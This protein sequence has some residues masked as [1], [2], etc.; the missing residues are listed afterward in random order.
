M[1]DRVIMVPGLRFQCG[2]MAERQDIDRLEQALGV[3]L[4]RSLG[5]FL[6]E[7]DGCAV[8]LSGLEPPSSDKE[9][10]KLIWSCEETLERN[11][12]LRR[13]DAET[14]DRTM[15][16]ADLLWFVEE[17][18]GILVG[19]RVQHGKVAGPTVYSYEPGRG[20]EP[21]PRAG[22]L[23]QYLTEMVKDYQGK[24]SIDFDAL[25]W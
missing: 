24:Y 11:Q 8:T 4:P 7:M 13:L 9:M 10:I 20:A 2:D 1:W 18:D 6:R 19:F 23:R 21:C 5:G 14:P 16:Y 15:T 12:A 17:L 22:S 25:G 3:T